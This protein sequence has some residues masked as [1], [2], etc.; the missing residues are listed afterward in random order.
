VVFETKFINL[1]QAM[2]TATYYFV[3]LGVLISDPKFRLHLNFMK[4][5]AVYAPRS[6]NQP[7][8]EEAAL[9]VG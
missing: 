3:P 9:G 2:A 7:A 1:Q 6:C 5:S 8:H 4:V